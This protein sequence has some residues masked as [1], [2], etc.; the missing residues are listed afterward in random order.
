[1]L[2]LLADDARLWVGG[3]E[4]LWVVERRAAGRSLPS[5]WVASR[6]FE[7]PDVWDIAMGSGET[8]W[9]GTV[10]GL[11]RLDPSAA[12]PTHVQLVSVA[13]DPIADPHIK[14]LHTDRQG[15]L[16]I[17]TNSEGLFVV[18]PSAGL[19]CCSTWPPNCR[20]VP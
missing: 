14:S 5:P 20:V 7:L 17:G 1:M 6:R 15:R 4:G 12:Q 2:A 16:W 3:T 19:G 18:D 11:Y 8:R 10:K 9:A 13:G